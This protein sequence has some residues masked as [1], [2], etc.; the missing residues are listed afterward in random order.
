MVVALL[1]VPSYLRFE[2]RVAEEEVG[3][4]CLAAAILGASI[5][6][7]AIGRALAR[8][9]SISRYVQACGG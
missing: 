8:I 3:F 6:A 9:D 2:P 7:A 1:C 4:L 5:C